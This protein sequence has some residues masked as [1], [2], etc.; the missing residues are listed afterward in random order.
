MTIKNKVSGIPISY[1]ASIPI[2]RSQY[3]KSLRGFACVRR[4]KSFMM[5]PKGVNAMR[6]IFSFTFALFT[7]ITIVHAQDAT[8]TPP[9]PPM[10]GDCPVFPADN[11]WNMD[12]SDLPVDPNSDDY[13]AAISAE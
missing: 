13:I 3:S 9:A 2:I 6:R 4:N 11:A 8:E 1:I 10:V 12:V 5:K 7:M